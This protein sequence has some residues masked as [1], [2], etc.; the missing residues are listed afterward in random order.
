MICYLFDQ[1]R[2]IFPS[3]VAVKSV[4]VSVFKVRISKYPNGRLVDT[5]QRLQP[6]SL[7]QIASYLHIS[8]AKIKQE[9]DSIECRKQLINGV[10]T[11]SIDEP[12]VDDDICVD[13]II[14]EDFESYMISSNL[15]PKVKEKTVAPCFSFSPVP[16]SLKLKYP[17]IKSTPILKTCKPF[18]IPNIDLNFI[19][20]SRNEF[21]YKTFIHGVEFYVTFIND[22]KLTVPCLESIPILR[23]VDSDMI[24]VNLLILAGKLSNEEG[25]VVLSL[26]YS[27]VRNRLGSWVLLARGRSLCASLLL[28]NLLDEFLG[29]SIAR[30]F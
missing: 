10:L 15:V 4:F 17:P 14:E 8:A 18:K 28:E 21:I 13:D 29:R 5:I 11:Y 6:V 9:L 19:I 23:R 20:P 16:K 30:H 12:T 25:N 22:F 3:H 26:E 7:R 24:N 2:I 27:R 1:T